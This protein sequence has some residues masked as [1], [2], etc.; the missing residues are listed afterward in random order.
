MRA[1]IKNILI[2]FLSLI[3]I[4]LLIN[5][6]EDKG[7]KN[8]QELEIN[9]ID[10]GQGN[11]VLIKSNDKTLLIDGG[12]RSNS[13]YYYNFIKNKN[14]KKIDYMIASHYDEDHIAG[15][16]SILENYE[17]S[18]VLC[19]NYKK[20]TKIYKSFKKSLKKSNANIVYPKK[21]DEFNI[22]DANIQILWP[23]EYKKGV[24]NDNSIVVKLR[25]GNMS[26][27]FPA[28]A[29]TNVE[30]QLIYSGFNL[31]SDVLMLGHHGSK[32]STSKQFLKEVDPKLAVI[33]VGKNNRY[34]HPS[35]RVLKILN[36]KNIKIL[37]TDK[38]GD[39]S[40]K[41]D[42]KKIKITTKK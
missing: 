26:F 35:S 32:Y 36:D 28:D 21:G 30:D 13:S 14:V 1:K 27:L 24:D 25:Y 33:S 17:V 29:S 7:H 41:C 34:G 5:T 10:V 12:N 6:K 19:P 37:R 8:L 22:S 15:L 42:G 38:D 39:I 3:F 20:D 11:A 16:I 18:N 4:F 2:I 9:Y 23:N 40:I 31:K